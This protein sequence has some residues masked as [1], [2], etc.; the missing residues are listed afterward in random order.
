M[1][2]LTLAVVL[3]TVA[4]PGITNF[5]RNNSL[6]REAN[7][8]LSALQQA[9]SQAIKLQ[10]NVEVCFSANPNATTPTCSFG[11]GTGWIVFPDANSN[12]D[13]DSNTSE[14]ILARHAFDTNLTIVSDN[15]ALLSY[16]SSGFRVSPGAKTPLMNVLLCDSRGNKTVNST[17]STARVLLATNTGRA[18]I[19]KVKT[20]VT[21]ARSTIGTTLCP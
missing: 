21:M 19:S 10:S 16:A 20:D 7:D 13:H 1:A 8:L 4:V 5:I 3:A 17:D 12:W 2:A 11:S 14:P 18:R 15:N 6:T 9:R